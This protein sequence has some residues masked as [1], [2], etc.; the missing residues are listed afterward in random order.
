MSPG[1]SEVEQ[2]SNVNHLLK[3]RFRLRGHEC[4]EFAGLSLERPVMSKY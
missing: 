1:M 2:R 4:Q 3:L